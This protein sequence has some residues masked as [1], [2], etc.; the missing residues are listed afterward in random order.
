[1]QGRVV[2]PLHDADDNLVGYAGRLVDDTAVNEYH[3]K[4]K[5]P[6][7]RER[8]G[9]LLEFRKSLLVYNATRVAWPMEDIVIVEGFP[10]VW[11]LTQNGYPETVALMGNSCS[12]EQGKIILSGLVPHGRVW[13]LADG[14][15]GGEH[16]AESVFAQLAPHRWVR[17]VKLNPGEQPTDCLADEIDCLLRH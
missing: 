6:S 5:F 1:M 3:P 13:I 4:Y 14:D 15:E 2:I 17:W 8:E 7:S 9:K 11:W 16:C 10:S 12:E